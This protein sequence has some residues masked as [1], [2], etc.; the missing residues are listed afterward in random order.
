MNPEEPHKKFAREDSVRSF[1]QDSKT[2]SATEQREIVAFKFGGS[3]LLGA[4]RML[5]AAAL[6][7][8]RG[9]EQKCSGGRFRDEGSNGPLT[10]DCPLAGSRMPHGCPTRRRI[11]I[12]ATHS[13]SSR[14]QS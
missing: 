6:V 5:H 8:R 12:P 4:E 7:A 10:R 9:R 11:R 2:N 13:G 14:S 3:S 1:L